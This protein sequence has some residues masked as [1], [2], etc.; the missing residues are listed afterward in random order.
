MKRFL[1]GVIVLI[2]VAL[3]C[4]VLLVC[5]GFAAGSRS[6]PTTRQ[7]SDFRHGEERK[8]TVAGS[9]RHRRKHVD[10]EKIE[11]GDGDGR[12]LCDSKAL[13]RGRYV[14]K[15]EF[16]GFA[17]QTQEVGVNPENPTGKSGSGTRAWLRGSRDE[18]RPIARMPQ[19]HVGSRISKPRGRKSPRW[20]RRR[21]ANGNGNGGVSSNDL[22]SLP[23]NGAGADLSTESVNVA[24]AAGAQPGFWQRQRRGPPAADS[25][26][27]RPRAT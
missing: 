27:S 19:P 12:F 13:P 4:A 17:P 3:I 15:V 20:I 24:G 10:G 23:M 7:L 5:L 6:A 8:D 14:I 9:D 18:N 21:T 22:S 2:C 11:C 26:I 25:G 16:M 1:R